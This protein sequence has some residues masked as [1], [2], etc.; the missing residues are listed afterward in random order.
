[1]SG[2]SDVLAQLRLE[3]KELQDQLARANS[4]RTT[5]AHS[6]EHLERQLLR[7]RNSYDAALQKRQQQ[8]AE[9]E[10]LTVHC[11]TFLQAS[12]EPRCRCSKRTLQQQF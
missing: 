2:L 9:L 5:S 7:A 1:M 11:E 3:N 10:Q 8:V 12:G 4:K 6:L